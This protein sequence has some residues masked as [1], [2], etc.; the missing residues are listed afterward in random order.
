MQSCPPSQ[1]ETV[2][3]Y[4][5]LKDVGQTLGNKRGEE[6]ADRKNEE[7]GREASEDASQCFHVLPV[8]PLT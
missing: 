4:L 8:L 3:E 1:V 5:K 6:G 2:T 7:G